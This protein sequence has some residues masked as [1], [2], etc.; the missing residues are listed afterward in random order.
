M[1]FL[2][3]F[4]YGIAKGGKMLEYLR[5]AAE[6]PVAKFLMGILIFSFVGWG[7]AEWIFGMSAGDT[8]I[9]RVGGAKVS[10]QEYSNLKSNELADT[11]REEQRKIYTDPVAMSAFQTK[12]LNKLSTQHMIAN[13]ADDLG[14]IISDREVAQIIREMPEFQQDGKFSSARFDFITQNSGYSESAI[15]NMIRADRLKY[16]VLAPTDLAVK[17]PDF[18][19]KATYNA[20]YGERVIEYATVKMGDFK[21][22]TPSDDELKQYYAQNPRKIAE[23]RNVSY[24]LVPGELDKPDVYEEKIKIAQKVEDDIIGGETLVNTAK[25]HNITYVKHDNVSSTNLPKDKLFDETLLSKAFDMGEGEESEM[26]ETKSGFVIMRVEKITPEH[27]AEFESVKKDLV[28]EWQHNEQKKQAYIRA[29]ELLVALNKDGNLQNS[30]TATVSRTTGA[31]L[32]V[33]SAAFNKAIGDKSI[34]ETNNEYYVLHINSEK[35]PTMD[36]KKMNALRTEVSNMSRYHIAEDFDSY[37]K[38]KYPTKINEKI[39]NRYV[40]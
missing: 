10:V 22:G 26:I 34:V 12:I 21:I 20:R 18:A 7:V 36:D 37:L 39:Y 29:N 25:K 23:S 38:R 19:V 11:P 24:V 8:T 1:L 6:K 40:K 17:T 35:Q 30:K 16:M 33:L 3:L 14:Y 2:V 32:S 13:R 15:A 27:N 4:C 5:N 28:K 31:P 9:M